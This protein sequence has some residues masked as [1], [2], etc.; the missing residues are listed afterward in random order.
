[1]EPGA[2]DDEAHPNSLAVELGAIVVEVH[3]ND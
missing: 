3:P 2:I 1:M